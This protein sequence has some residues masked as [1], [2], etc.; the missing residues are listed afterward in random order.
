MNKA[1]LFDVGRIVCNAVICI[2][3]A[4][5]RAG[6]GRL[7]VLLLLIGAAAGVI[8]NAA[9]FVARNDQLRQTFKEYS[10]SIAIVGAAAMNVQLVFEF[11]AF[12]LL[13][14]PLLRRPRI[15]R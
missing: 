1:E 5:V 3:A 15:G 2:F 13:T 4:R 7:W 10:Q 9:I 11:A 14:V 6:G 12:V 8:L